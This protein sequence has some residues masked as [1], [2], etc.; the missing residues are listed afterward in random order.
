MYSKFPFLYQYKT[1][2]KD[3]N[4]KTTLKE[5]WDSFRNK[6]SDSHILKHWTVHH[7]SI[8]EPHFIMKVVN[9]Y[10]TALSRQV[11]EAVRIH[12]RGLVLN[13]KSEYSRCSISR[14]SLDQQEHGTPQDQPKDD[15]GEDL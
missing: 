15:S 8:G 11:G 1:W 6:H 13:S 12:K 4:F 2:I 10:R 3:I 7:G 5:H 14:L 9:F